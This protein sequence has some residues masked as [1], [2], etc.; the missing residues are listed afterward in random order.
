[1]VDK[2]GLTLA[3]VDLVAIAGVACYAQGQIS[4]IDKSVRVLSGHLSSTTRSVG[5][6]VKQTEDIKTIKKDLLSL[7]TS[8]KRM[9][10]DIAAMKSDVESLR[11]QS[12]TGTPETPVILKG[13]SSS[14]SS[15]VEEVLL[16]EDEDGDGE[17]L[18]SMLASMKTL[19]K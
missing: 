19:T 18:E 3:V 11:S 16:E 12:R 4:R 14:L 10:E 7:K 13:P 2:A 5:D 9:S 1:M 6:I 8:M 15:V 17:T